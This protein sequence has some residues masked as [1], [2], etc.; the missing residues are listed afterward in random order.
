MNRKDH[1]VQLVAAG[2]ATSWKD[3]ISE[4]A[5]VSYCE[6]VLDLIEEACPEEE[7]TCVKCGQYEGPEGSFHPRKVKELV[8]QAIADERERCV[9]ELKRVYVQLGVLN[10][11]QTDSR[12]L[13]SSG[14]AAIRDAK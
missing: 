1:L 5:L 13:L 11:A 2:M 9:S 12:E 7:G 6:G 14:I 3:E 4:K 8:A 10:G